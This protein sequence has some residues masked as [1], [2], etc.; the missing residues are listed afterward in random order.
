MSDDHHQ[1]GGSGSGQPIRGITRLVNPPEDD[2]EVISGEEDPVERD[3]LGRILHVADHALRPGKD[4]Q[5]KDGR[6][7]DGVLHRT[8]RGRVH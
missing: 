6:V 1:R 7:K 3:Y 2:H 4:G 8:R 5:R